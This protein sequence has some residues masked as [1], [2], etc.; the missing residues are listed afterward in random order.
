[1]FKTIFIAIVSVSL[2]SCGANTPKSEDPTFTKD[3][4][5]MT[6]KSDMQITGEELKSYFLPNSI[7]I[8]E[9]YLVEVIQDRDTFEKYLHPA[10]TMT[11]KF[12]DY[13]FNKEFVLVVAG[14]TSDLKPYFSVESFKKKD[15]VLH[16]HLKEFKENAPESFSITP[17]VAYAFPKEGISKIMV[18]IND[19]AIEKSVN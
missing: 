14:K 12:R 2:W 8:N 4:S 15:N 13:D 7:Q 6:E 19:Y 11:S 1:M 5:N 17:L 16:V 18:S 10:A 9:P 3:H